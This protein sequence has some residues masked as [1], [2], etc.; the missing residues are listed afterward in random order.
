MI[1]ENKEKRI[2]TDKASAK[3]RGL[4]SRAIREWAR[5]NGFQV[6]ERGKFSADLV[7]KYVEAPKGM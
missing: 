6:G 4:D 1:E 3:A 5:E 2:Y 7:Q